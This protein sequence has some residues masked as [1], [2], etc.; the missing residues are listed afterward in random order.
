MKWNRKDADFIK[1]LFVV[2]RKSKSRRHVLG[3][4]SPVLAIKFRDKIPLGEFKTT[5]QWGKTVRH[6]KT[7]VRHILRLLILRLYILF[8]RNRNPLWVEMACLVRFGPITIWRWAQTLNYSRTKCRIK[9]KSVSKFQKT[10]IS[11]LGQGL[12]TTSLVVIWKI[13]LSL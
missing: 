5:K 4:L 10:L 3:T 9:P 6:E 11:M 7:H 2:A 1:Q 12:I 8:G 13:A